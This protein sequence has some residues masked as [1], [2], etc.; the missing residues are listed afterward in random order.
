LIEIVGYLRYSSH[1]QKT[2][3]SIFILFSMGAGILPSV[4]AEVCIGKTPTRGPL[5]NRYPGNC[6]PTRMG[7]LVELYSQDG[8]TL[9]LKNVVHDG[10]LGFLV[11]PTGQLK[12]TILAQE[13]IPTK[14]LSTT[15]RL[16]FLFRRNSLRF[17]ENESALR[18]DRPMAKISGFV[19]DAS[20]VGMPG[21]SFNLFDGAQGR[22]ALTYRA[23]SIDSANRRIQWNHNLV[24]RQPL[25]LNRLEGLK[26]MQ[27]FLA[28]A[29]HN[30]L[31][32]PFHTL[33]ENS[34]TEILKSMGL[35]Q[36]DALLPLKLPEVMSQLGFI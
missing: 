4:H 17:Y 7:V 18:A 30:G 33:R 29:H 32:A 25:K 21:E 6:I 35:K 11:I 14:D 8:R 3:V 5:L 10:K 2:F 22:Y 16:E 9:T 20:P 34:A 13:T 19:M 28:R 36:V 27:A 15:S 12:K 26:V 23:Q 24:K 31:Q 1:V